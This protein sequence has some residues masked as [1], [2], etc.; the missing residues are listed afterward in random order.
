M[1]GLERERLRETRAAQ[2]YSG[3]GRA[4]CTIRNTIFS[5]R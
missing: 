3:S 5:T 1:K 4:A 2:N